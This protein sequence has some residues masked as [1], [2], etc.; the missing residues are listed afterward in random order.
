M[1]TVI[2]WLL[3]AGALRALSKP[4]TRWRAQAE[5]YRRRYYP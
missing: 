1:A 4:R 5:E 3:A 2:G